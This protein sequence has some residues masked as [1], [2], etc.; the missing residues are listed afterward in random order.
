ML[1]FMLPAVVGLILTGASVRAEDKP[2]AV[3]L[4]E[5]K[6]AVTT[7]E[8][9]GENI[10]AVIEALAAFEK[11]LTRNTLK[12]GEA[13]PE[14]TALREAVETAAKKGENVSAISK[15]LGLIEKA[16]TGREYERP[17]TP[18]TKLTPVPPLRRGGGI[19]INGRGGIVIG[20]AGDGVTTT[21]ITIS[22]GTFTIKARRNNVTYSVTGDTNGIN[23]PKIVIQDGEKKIE[24][25]DPKKVPEDYRPTAEKLLKM[26]TR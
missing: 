24:A 23:P 18:E 8:R 19:I 11:A 5:L 4:E 2:R 22:G 21:S 13:P 10:G 3:D 16:L 6:Y 15:E 14:L 25:D 26:I 17:K 7:A 1:R 9:K 12:T 20:D